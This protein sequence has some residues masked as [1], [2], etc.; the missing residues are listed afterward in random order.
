MFKV[1]NKCLYCKVW[2][3]FTPCSSV[4][5]VNF[6]QVIAGQIVS[7]NKLIENFHQFVECYTQ[8]LIKSHDPEIYISV[9]T[10]REHTTNI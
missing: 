1:N 9:M 2:T 4:S 7:S 6:E 5:I 10:A 8:N 3:Y